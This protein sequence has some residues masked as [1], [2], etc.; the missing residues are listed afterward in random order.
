MSCKFCKNRFDDLTE[1]MESTY[2]LVPGFCP[3]CGEI[4]DVKSKDVVKVAYIFPEKPRKSCLNCIHC[5]GNGE[6]TPYN[7]ILGEPEFDTYGGYCG[8]H[9][10]EEE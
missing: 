7:C 4:P 2:G 8:Y 1:H 3:I 6:T 9:Q 5:G 10:Y